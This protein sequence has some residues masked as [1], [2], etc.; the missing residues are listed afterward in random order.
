MVQKFDRRPTPINDW[1]AQTIAA[2]FDTFSDVFRA[3]FQCG[4]EREGKSAEFLIMDIAGYPRDGVADAA[5]KCRQKSGFFGFDTYRFIEVAED[6]AAVSGS[7]IGTCT[8]E[9]SI[10][11]NRR[12]NEGPEL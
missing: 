4:T 7:E 6:Y 11:Q 9:E 12:L 5:E 10:R 8:T 1:T 2:T 3:K